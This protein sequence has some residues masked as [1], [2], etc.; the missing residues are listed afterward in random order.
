[1]IRRI[2]WLAVAVVA[3]SACSGGAGPA[4]SQGSGASGVQPGTS[5][6]PGA[7]SD[8]GSLPGASADGVQI[9]GSLT[10]SGAYEATWTWTPGDAGDVL[11]GLGGV[12]LRS[13]KGT[14]ATVNAEMDGTITF[15]SLV[16]AIG[17]AATGTGAQVKLD[18]QNIAVCS[19]TADTDLSGAPGG[20]LRLK[21]SLTIV[22]GPWC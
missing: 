14:F 2:A 15:G 16:D 22:G 9:L 17:T 21:G 12:T 8:G 11:N 10:T 7:S 13:D 5:A 20:A 6:A 4:A 1:M 18:S 3:F 19:F